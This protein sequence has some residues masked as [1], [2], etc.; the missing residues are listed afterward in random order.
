MAFCCCCTRVGNTARCQCFSA[1]IS[2]G[3]HWTVNLIAWALI[4]G[5][6][7]AFNAFC[8][9]KLHFGVVIGNMCTCLALVYTFGATTFTDPGWLPRQTPEQLERQKAEVESGAPSAIFQADGNAADPG[10]ML[11]YTACSRCNV[12]R[13][14]GTQHC[15]DCGLCCRD[16]DHRA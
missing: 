3:P 9:I 6:T 14:A 7:A 13:Q 11:A 8:G 1:R 16:L 5:I 2:I 15:Y 4:L 10:P 12:L